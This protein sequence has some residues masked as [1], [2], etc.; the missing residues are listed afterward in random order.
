VG[1]PAYASSA[2]RSSLV[3]VA[4]ERPNAR[5]TFL[6]L[7]AR[8]SAI[9]CAP[10]FPLRPRHPVIFGLVFARDEALIRQRSLNCPRAATSF[11]YFLFSLSLSLFT[12]LLLLL[13]LL[14]PPISRFNRARLGAF[15]SCSKPTSAFHTSIHQL[16]RIFLRQSR[17]GAG[18]FINTRKYTC[19]PCPSI[20][21]LILLICT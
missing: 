10:R 15:V 17:P 6:S 5:P 18:R 13:L 1:G 7:A 14:L 2:P 16:H 12:C 8:L 9:R 19:L 4:S 20:I 11:F 3:S 21:F